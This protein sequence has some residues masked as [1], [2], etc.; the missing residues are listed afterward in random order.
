MFPTSEVNEII[1]DKPSEGNE[2]FT[3][4]GIAETL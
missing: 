2:D 3:V 4:E 1:K